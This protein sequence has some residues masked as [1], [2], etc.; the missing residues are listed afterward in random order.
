M[1]PPVS[2]L[3]RSRPRAVLL[4]PRGGNGIRQVINLNT[5]PAVSR[6]RWGQPQNRADTGQGRLRTDTEQTETEQ[7]GQKQNRDRTET[8]TETRQVTLGE[9]GKQVLDESDSKM[10]SDISRCIL[11]RTRNGE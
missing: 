7:T 5:D 2:T 9:R 1:Y 10:Q 4:T 8:E 11:D 6:E 3:Q